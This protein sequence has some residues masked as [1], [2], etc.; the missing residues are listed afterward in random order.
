M[1][2]A[3]T[4]SEVAGQETS[5]SE[6]AFE[7]YRPDADGP[8]DRAAAA[9]LV[10]RAAFGMPKE[11]VERALGLGPQA[12][13]RD[14]FEAKP[15]EEDVLFAYQMAGR[16]GS[17]ESAQSAWVYRMLHGCSPALEKLALFWHG[18][19]A[20]SEAKVEDVGLM[21]RQLQLFRD[22]GAGP[23]AELLLEVAKDPAMLIWLDSNSNRK[24]KPN[25]N[26]AREL[27]ELFS[28]GIGNYTEADVKEAARAFTGWHVR[29]REFWL[30]RN[31]HDEGPKELFGNS[32]S[33]DG[34]D[35]VRLCVEQTACA[36]HVGAK[37][38]EFYVRLRPEP[39]L[40]RLL[41]K[42]LRAR[43]MQ[44]RDFL[45]ELLSSKLFY[46]AASRRA[47]VA[48]PVDF[49]VG[50]ARTLGAQVSPEALVD[51]MKAMG[52]EL[53]APPSVKGWDMGLSWLSST[54]LFA[55]YAFA[56]ALAGGEDAG[57]ASKMRARV[58]WD[59]LGGDAVAVVSRFFP[60]GC[61]PQVL[62]DVRSAGGGDPR[63]TALA[64][65]Q[66]PEHQFI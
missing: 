45:V 28:L 52:Q 61:S 33:L 46:E 32:G 43:G 55:R 11:L 62:N 47:L 37:L 49:S 65:L 42:A 18:H 7:P 66:L 40:R 16:V 63:A 34:E 20:T 8:W 54:T 41:G 35:V 14:L 2:S 44:V 48:T 58:D 29:G 22:R 51:A 6:A 30:N 23:F 4:V 25:E 1:S 26:F 53:L 19:F 21:R 9:H 27:M 38:F 50:S 57:G 24:G 31:A 17:L 15:E 39:E 56:G 5:G 60:D 12:G 59:S 10:R 13:A 36:E 64:C 3:S